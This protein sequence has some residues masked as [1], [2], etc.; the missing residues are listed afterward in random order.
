MRCVPREG[1]R[2]HKMKRG[3][4]IGGVCIVKEGFKLLRSGLSLFVLFYQV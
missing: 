4:K 1:S 2:G 3:V